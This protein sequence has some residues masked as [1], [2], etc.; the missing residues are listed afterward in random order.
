MLTSLS[1]KNRQLRPAAW[2]FVAALM[3]GLTS[4]TSHAQ[5]LYQDNFNRADSVNNL[6]S[7]QSGSGSPLAWSL[8]RD[9]DN[10]AGPYDTNPSVGPD[11][12]I[13]GNRLRINCAGTS[14]GPPVNNNDM[15]SFYVNSNLDSVLQYSATFHYTHL[16]THQYD[17]AQPG[18]QT[19]G[20]FFLLP[21]AQ[22]V[23]FPLNTGYV[24]RRSTTDATSP[25]L[26]YFYDGTARSGSP[27]NIPLINLGAPLGDTSSVLV[28]QDHTIRVDVYGPSGN[29][30]RLT[31]NGVLID[32]D[33]S[34]GALY[35]NGTPDHVLLGFNALGTAQRRV[36]A[37]IDD[38]VV[39]VPEPG[40]G[41]LLLIGLA[42]LARRAA[43]RRAT[44]R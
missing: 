37:T 5:V 11:V 36:V 22:G 31:I 17:A 35:N 18:S 12:E 20:G 16:S 32:E 42:A 38:L 14:P 24:I 7:A 19:N 26:V 34:L 40:A 6:G 1:L 30:A 43:G 39:A 21:R 33:R 9:P 13:F 44:G 3:W 15:A 8:Q 10:S 29:L 41:A 27:A 28:D 2:T 4:L 25:L 23:D